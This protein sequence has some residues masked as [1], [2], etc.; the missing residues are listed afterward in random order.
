M[1][2]ILITCLLLFTAVATFAVLGVLLV[3][4]RKVRM[5]NA[6]R[7]AQITTLLVCI[8][9]YLLTHGQ[10]PGLH[11]RQIDF[12]S[13]ALVLALLSYSLLWAPLAHLLNKPEYQ[14]EFGDSFMLSMLYTDSQSPNLENPPAE[15]T[16]PK[17]R[18]SR[19]P[20]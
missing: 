9:F 5:K 4:L 19:S 2:P 13:I 17:Q 16:A 8:L 11:L 1:S 15:A 18:T 10:W 12:W 20:R 14:E 3:R 6:S 7:Y